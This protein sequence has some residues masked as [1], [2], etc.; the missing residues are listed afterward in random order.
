MKR[1]G[2][3]EEVA[4]LILFLSSDESSYLTGHNIFVDGANNLQEYKGTGDLPA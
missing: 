4:N 1:A 2:K 3:P